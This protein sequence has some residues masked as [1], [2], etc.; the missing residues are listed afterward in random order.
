MLADIPKHRKG[1]I[2]RCENADSSGIAEGNEEARFKLRVKSGCGHGV[3]V[4][5]SYVASVDASE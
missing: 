1:S 4:G 2:G 5:F 3:L